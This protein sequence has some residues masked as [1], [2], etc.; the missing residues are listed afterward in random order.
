MPRKR[1]SANAESPEPVPDGVRLVGTLRGHGDA[2]GDIA[3]SPDGGLLATTSADTTV[4]IWDGISYRHLHT[5]TAHKGGVR[6]AAFDRYG[7]ILATGDVDGIVNLWQVGSWKWLKTL[8][9]SKDLT[10]IQSL[11]FGPDQDVLACGGHRLATLIDIASG[12]IRHRLHEMPEYSYVYQVAFDPTGAMVATGG[13]GERVQ[14]WDTSDGQLLTTLTGHTNYV[15][16]VTFSPDGRLL[17]SGGSDNTI[18]I[19]DTRSYQLVRT[20]E[21]HANNVRSLSFLT[22]GRLL[23]SKS[24]DGSVRLWDCATWTPAGVIAEPGSGQWTPRLAFHPSQPLLATAGSDP[25]K[26]DD[27]VVHLW[28]LD[29]DRL[30]GE[31]RPASVTYTSA[32]I[33]LVGESGVG[34]TGLGYRLAHGEFKDHPSTHGQQFWLL[35]ELGATRADGTECEAILWDLAGQP[36]YRLIHALFLDDADLALVLF[37]PTRDDDPLRGVDYWLRQLG[38]TARPA[39]EG[40]K[41]E[42]IL[43]AARS[44]RGD[45]RLTSG[46]IGRFCAERGI[47]SHVTTSALT[48]EGLVGL[49]ALMRGAVDWESRPATVT[50]ATFKW[51]KDAVL[52][53]KESQATERVIVSPA[54]LRAML[55]RDDPERR[56]T[57]AELLAA[58]GHLVNHGYVALPRTSQGD[59]RILLAPEL[60]NNVAASIVLEARR[61]PKGLGSLEEQR[62]L[63]GDYAFPELLALDADERDVLLDSAVAMFLAHHVC[64][65]ETD[66]LSAR[67]YLVFPE[68][69]NLKRPA[70]K[71]RE[72]VSDGVAYTVTG[73]VENVYA[74]LVVLL[75]YTDVFARISQWRNQAEYVV[76]DGL[77]CGFRLEAEREGELDFVLYFGSAVGAPIRMLF[78]GLF[79]SFLARRD[80]TVRRFEPVTCSNGHQLN[81]AVVREQIAAG[82]ET[83]F[84]TRCGERLSLPR[85]DVPIQLARQQRADLDIQRR[86]AGQRSRFEQALFR[87]KASLAADPAAQPT[88]FISYA[89]GHPEHEQWVERELATDLAKA[90]IT[91]I[92][93]RWENARIGASVPRFV[94][95]AA[96]ADRVVV[97]GTPLYRAKY[98]NDN[99]MGGFVVAA[100]GD[101]IGHRLTGTESSK[102]TVLPVLLDGT[103]ETALPPL[104][105]GRVYGDFR[106]PDQ[107]F[108]NAFNLI[109]SVHDIPPNDPACAELRRDLEDPPR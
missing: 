101:I 17:A 99:P 82:N 63:A 85:A 76:G 36:D 97:V 38:A 67:V 40:R 95:R 51:I 104:L 8:D 42:V 50:T 48:G 1:R 90:G 86:T 77:V 65:R 24:L 13:Y 4:C 19:W 71:D 47:A 70:V 94:E 62:V 22:D 7:R 102:L 3:W 105:H 31:S 78:Q 32:K 73:A 33:V 55:E 43:V 93:D 11:A 61:N 74:S 87:L 58:V 68:L 108:V 41:R 16:C 37:D 66:P 30:L 44:D 103:A 45:A 25:G 12:K 23:A 91:V 49:V 84:C 56:Y 52:G 88:C 15:I 9:L 20:L 2:V 35:D 39:Q 98:D 72:A 18:N 96:S 69:I 57:E 83:V 28:Q 75:G 6:G 60:L 59:S 79:E 34:K 100:E 26:D 89:W 107:Y 21:G 54:E 80:L 53:L 29:V 27:A 46:E 64:F 106:Q 92:L 109:L 81:R 14:V 5:I 10:R